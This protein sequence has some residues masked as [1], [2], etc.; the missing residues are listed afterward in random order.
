MR[1]RRRSERGALIPTVGLLLTVLLPSSAMAVDLGMQRVVRR[2]MQTLADMVA[3]DL[4]RLVDGR[5]AAQ[6][7]AGYN[8]QPSLALALSRSVARNDDEVLGDDPIVTAKLAHMDASTG[9]LDTDSSGTREVAGTEVPNAI[10]ITAS[11]AVDFAFVPGRGGAVRTAVAVPSPSA[12]FRLGSFAGGVDTSSANLLNQLLPGLL[13]FSSLSGTVVGYDGLATAD[14]TLLDLVGVTGLGVGTPEELLQL[15]GLSI[16]QFYAALATVLQNNGGPAAS[17]TLLEY[18]STHANLT[19]T[20]AIADLLDITTADTAALAAKFKILDLV[21]GAAYLANDDNSLLIPGLSASLPVLNTGATMSLMVVEAPK[22]ACGAVGEAKARTGQV[23]LNVTGTIADLPVSVPLIG[24]FTVKTGVTSRVFLAAAEG[25]LTH[26]VCGDATLTTNAEGIDVQVTSGLASVLRVTESLQISATLNLAVGVVTVDISVP[27]YAETAG[28]TTTGTVSFRH[29]DDAYGTAK[30]YG[31]GVIVPS[32][33][34][35][36]VP[37]GTKV[38]LK[39]LIGP[40]VDVD[41]STVP[42][43]SAALATVLTTATTNVNNTLVSQ[44]NA[45]LVPMLA[46]QVGVTVGGAD[47]FALERPS[48]NDPRLAG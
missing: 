28:G 13:N 20:I 2:D 3:L 41:V 37:T 21:T 25:A 46:R 5:T 24:G 33:T 27:A 38:K 45:N 17:V 30:R 29:P 26:I 18:L 15:D 40:Q 9:L 7:N 12:C 44:L 1:R 36:S 47:M 34:A 8:G 43:L 14:V 4:V 35:P 32:I 42:G 23:D 39:P 19:Q 11:G 48:C 22:L 16:G 31:S 6:I 10:E